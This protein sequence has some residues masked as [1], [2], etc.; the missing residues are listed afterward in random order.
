MFHTNVNPALDFILVSTGLNWPM[1]G[2]C[3]TFG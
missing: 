3:G 2:G 1:V